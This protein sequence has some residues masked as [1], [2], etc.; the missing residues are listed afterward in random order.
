MN[1]FNLLAEEGKYYQLSQSILEYI[2]GADK[3]S[4][5]LLYN[6]VIVSNYYNLH[7]DS[8]AE[9]SSAIAKKFSPEE[10]KT[11]LEKS[12]DLLAGRKE[13]S[14]ISKG[15]E[16]A[17]EGSSAAARFLLEIAH[18]MIMMGDISTVRI[19]LY[20]CKELQ[21]ESKEIQ[22][23]LLLG[24]GLLH[25]ATKSYTQAFKSLI[26]YLEISSPDEEVFCTALISGIR[27]ERTHSFAQLISLWQGERTRA[28]AL[29][30]ALEKGE[31]EEAAAL[32]DQMDK[33]LTEMVKKKALA[34]KLL[35]YFFSNK[36]RHI[37]LSVLSG[38]TRVPEPVLEEAI[39]DILGSG[40][41]EG[42]IDSISGSF[43]YKWMGYKHLSPQEISL[44]RETVGEIRKRVDNLIKET[45]GHIEE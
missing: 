13:G 16:M 23:K 12:L 42:S 28:L 19:I 45:A 38:V 17:K 26:E 29:A 18:S 14:T 37:S 10:A 27:S 21:M 31:V 39:L 44:V 20:D 43:S 30:E 33:S 34:V 6:T 8:F 4:L 36:D 15:I 25:Y 9:I 5:Y 2:P 22:R 1:S 41:M 7:P 3:E 40:L 11:L 35:N 32:T 24:M